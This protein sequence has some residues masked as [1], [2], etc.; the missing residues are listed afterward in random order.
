[1]CITNTRKLL[2]L[3]LPD[4]GLFLLEARAPDAKAQSWRI[5]FFLLAVPDY[6]H[7]PLLIIAILA[8]LRNIFDTNSNFTV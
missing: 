4:F 5:V 2:L 1:M 7:N 8:H 3:T 6:M